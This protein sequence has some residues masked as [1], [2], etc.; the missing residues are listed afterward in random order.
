MRREPHIIGTRKLT[1][2]DTLRGEPPILL[3]IS[4]ID[5]LLAG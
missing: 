1:V 3:R 2:I 5:A 4:I